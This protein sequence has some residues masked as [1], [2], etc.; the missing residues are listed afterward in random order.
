MTFIRIANFVEAYSVNNDGNESILRRYQN[1]APGSNISYNGAS[2]PYLSFIYQ[3]A[4]KTRTGDNLQAALMLSTN[5]LSQGIARELIMN[6]DHARI[7]TVQMSTRADTVSR[8]LTKEDWLVATMT[9]D[10]ATIEIILSS[11]IDAVGANAPTRVLTRT[12]VGH[13][14]ATGSLRSG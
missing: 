14:P 6:R 10:P 1:A 7:Y 5:E 13:L 8:L 2:F 9:Y 3:G 11:G 4:A 12:M